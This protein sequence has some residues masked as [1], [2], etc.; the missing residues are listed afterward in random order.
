MSGVATGEL[1]KGASRK[2]MTRNGG[3]GCMREPETLA[4]G[5]NLAYWWYWYFT[6]VGGSCRRF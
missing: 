6:S 2:P 5:F 1:F 4:V 3:C